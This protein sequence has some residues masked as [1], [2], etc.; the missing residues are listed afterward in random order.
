MCLSVCACVE[1]AVSF[2]PRRL[3]STLHGKTFD[4]IVVGGGHNGLVSV[5][6]GSWGFI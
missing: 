4:A 5:S 3:K 6:G 2:V 1:M